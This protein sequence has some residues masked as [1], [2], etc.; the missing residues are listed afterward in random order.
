MENV[1]T[2]EQQSR[3]RGRIVTHY[4]H[5]SWRLA[6]ALV[7]VVAGF[8]TLNMTL[9]DSGFAVLNEHVA[10]FAAVFARMTRQ[11]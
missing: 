6:G 4:A 11:G 10:P 2:T 5:T 8:S 1:I 9:A 7:A 3:R